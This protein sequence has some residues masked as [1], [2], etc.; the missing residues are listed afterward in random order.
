MKALKIVTTIS[1]LF[2]LSLSTAG[3]IFAANAADDSLVVTKP[4]NEKE[5][6]NK[7]EKGLIHGLTSDVRGVVESSL[8]NAINYKVAYP[9]FSSEK[10]NKILNRIALE[11]DN[12]SLRYKAYLTLAYY[13]NQSQFESP[14]SLLSILDYKYQNG[15]FF[16][17]QDAVQ[18]EHFTSNL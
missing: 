4:Q 14:E 6:F 16:Y 12:H 5:L 2:I 1:L 3:E 11:G 18:S 15:I 13:K 17:L 8:Y 7:L 9:E 10:V